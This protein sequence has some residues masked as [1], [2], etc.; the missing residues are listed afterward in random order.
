MSAR[1]LLGLTLLCFLFQ[2]TLIAHADTADDN[3]ENDSDFAI[4]DELEETQ[5]QGGCRAPGRGQTEQ[6]QAQAQ[7]QAQTPPQAED[8]PDDA[9]KELM[10]QYQHYLQYMKEKGN[11]E[12]PISYQEF[13]EYMQI[14][15]QGQAEG[16]SYE[17]TQQRYAQ[18]QQ[19]KA[20][21][22][23]EGQ[24]EL[25][26]NF[27]DLKEKYPDKAY[28][29]I[30]DIASD[31]LPPKAFGCGVVEIPKGKFFM[32]SE[33]D[34]NYAE[35]GESPYRKIKISHSFYMDACEVTNGQFL[36]FW[37][38][39]KLKGKTEA[40]KYGWSFVFE[41][42]ISPEVNKEVYS[43]VQGAE[44]WLPVPGADFRHPSGPDGDFNAVLDHPAIHIGWTDANAY[45]RHSG[46]R[47]PTESEWEYAC[48]G[49]L[50]KKKFPWGDDRT[51]NLTEHG[52]YSMNIFTGEP[53]SKD[54]GRDGWE[55]TAVVGSYSPNGYGLY[56]MTG[57]VWEWVHDFWSVRPKIPPDGKRLIDPKGPK[58]GRDRVMKGGSY[59]CHPTTCRRYRCSGR[60]HAEPDSSTGNLGLRCVY[61][62]PPPHMKTKV[63]DSK[64]EL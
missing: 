17:E 24:E 39:R 9:T 35:D 36:R 33:D 2:Q 3:D 20:M 14:M 31:K 45:C 40:E 38:E 15:Q 47:L 62:T 28:A 51:P 57:N 19:Q 25:K 60:S 6:A 1:S 29:H 50:E 30:A 43:A 26:N 27:P 53:Y 13:I 52:T 54:S 46:G 7:K 32:G 12:P 42:L 8:K 23:P 10:L 5:C 58:Q 44:W 11:G 64:T 48:R 59:M 37:E 63:V 21:Q 22:T 16:L 56:D 18:Q 61:D 55:S 41:L 34:E 4:L 49:G